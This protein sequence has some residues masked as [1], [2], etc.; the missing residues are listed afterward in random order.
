MTCVNGNNI[1]GNS[2]GQI[3]RPKSNDF[4]GPDTGPQLSTG[5]Q[6]GMSS[7]EIF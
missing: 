1:T 7:G 5:F 6:A 4:S 2:K 3:G